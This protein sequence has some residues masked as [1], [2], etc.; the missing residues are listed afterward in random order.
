MNDIM[1]IA[2]CMKSIWLINKKTLAKKSK[3][4]QK[5]KKK[6]FSE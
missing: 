6:N 5:N 4:K 3:M 2:K 1:K